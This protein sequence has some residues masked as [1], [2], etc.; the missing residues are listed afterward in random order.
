MSPGAQKLIA[1]ARASRPVDIV[2]K[3]GM[4][5]RAGEVY[6]PGDRL[7]APNALAEQLIASGAA[8]RALDSD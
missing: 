6:A 8:T 4:Y 2:M 7:T 1:S 5:V 3:E